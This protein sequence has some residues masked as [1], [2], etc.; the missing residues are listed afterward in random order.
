VADSVTLTS[1]EVRRRL[2]V[3][4]DR[5]AAAGGDPDMITV[6]AVTKG[7]DP[8]V[9]EAAVA[10][11][12][13]DVGESYAQEMAAKVA[14]LDVDA[15]WHFIGRLQRRR[16]RSVAGHV[17]LWHSVDRPELAAEIAR[18]SPGA[19]ILVQV[20][21]SAEPDK[22]GCAPG[23]VA[24]LVARAGDEGLVVRGLMSVGV[25]GDDDRTRRVFEAT[26]RLADELGLVERSM[27][28]S[29]DLEIAVASGATMV[30]VGTDLVGSRGEGGGAR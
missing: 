9:V 16:V 30:R 25:D 1:G 11:G 23:D 13:A 21:P 3:V 28:M 15:R 18:R 24:G 20:N 8:N 17:H 2:A 4:R 29:A 7:H 14:A 27:G 5:I 22:G 6:V 12:C 10:A 26:T 19:E